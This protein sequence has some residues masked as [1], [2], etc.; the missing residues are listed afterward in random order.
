MKGRL[1][2]NSNQPEI[3]EQVFYSRFQAKIKRVFAFIISRAASNSVF[4]R[5]T[6]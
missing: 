4:T 5:Y 3:T 2:V 1:D 6:I